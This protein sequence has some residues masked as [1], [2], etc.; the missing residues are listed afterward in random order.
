[1]KEESMIRKVEPISLIE[2]RK[3]FQK[4]PY[5]QLYA[6]YKSKGNEYRPS[7]KWKLVELLVNTYA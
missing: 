4:M 3:N 2:H 1:M 5:K 6:I 7:T